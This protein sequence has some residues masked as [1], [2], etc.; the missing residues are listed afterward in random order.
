MPHTFKWLS[1]MIKR[2]FFVACRTGWSCDKKRH[3]STH[4]HSI[5]VQNDLTMFFLWSLLL[6]QIIPSQVSGL[7][8]NSFGEK[9]KASDC[10]QEGMYNVW[11]GWFFAG[12][13]ANNQNF[14]P[15]LISKNLSRIFMG[16]R[17]K[18][19]FEKKVQNLPI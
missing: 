11:G 1:K 9:P 6:I 13:Q 14:V 3:P 5:P 15:S 18:F 17:Q 4:R 10:N 2:N 12:N 7:P 16:M 8:F 19:F